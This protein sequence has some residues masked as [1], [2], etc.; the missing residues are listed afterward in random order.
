MDFKGSHFKRDNVLWGVRWCVAYPISYSQLEEMM[1][2]VDRSTTR[3]T[4]KVSVVP[5]QVALLFGTSAAETILASVHMRAR[6]QMPWRLVA[7]SL[8]SSPVSKTRRIPVMTQAH[9]SLPH[10]KTGCWR[11]RCVA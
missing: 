11:R 5:Q 6:Q 8:K 10:P 4:P 3:D 7:G 2:D 1:E 9:V